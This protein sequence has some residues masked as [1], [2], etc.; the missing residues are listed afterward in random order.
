[1]PRKER[2]NEGDTIQIDGS[3]HD[4]L[5]NGRKITLHGA[6]DDATH[7]VVALYFCE[8]ECL[9]GYYQLLW[10]VFNRTGGM[11]PRAIYSDRSSCFFVNRGATLEE[12][13]AGAEKSETQWQKTCGELGI[14]LIAAY[15]PQ[16]KGRIERLWQTLQGRL[17]FIF[18]FLKIDT[19]ERA[20]AFLSDFIDGFNARFA[21]TPQDS[22][23]HWKAPPHCADFDFLFSVRAEKKTRASGSF[24]YHGYQFNLLSARSSCV[25]FTLCLSENYGLRAYRNGKYYDVELA[26]PMC[27]CVGDPMPAVEKDLIYRYFYADR[28]SGRATIRAG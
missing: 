15:S 6:I 28:H 19:I 20:N 4:W 13:L 3:R 25:R 1:M 23:L 7:K 16:A 11:L 17:P 10:Q 9:L 8:N 18:S 27:D 14:E 21:V 5:M 2:P 24:V 26:E 22:A 12:Q